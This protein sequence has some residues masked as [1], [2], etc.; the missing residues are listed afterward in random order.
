MLSSYLIKNEN[1][2]SR[3]YN[4]TI[5]S[6]INV[7]LLLS[8]IYMTKVPIIIYN[9]FKIF[10]IGIETIILIY[11]MPKPRLKSIFT[12]ISVI[13]IIISSLVYVGGITYNKYLESI[14]IVN[15]ENIDTDK[16]LN[17]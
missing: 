14:A 5:L 12:I 3:R 6:S 17:F 4:R 15:N 1:I 11:I 8:F 16:Y 10:L 9:N 2:E 13:S 7:Y